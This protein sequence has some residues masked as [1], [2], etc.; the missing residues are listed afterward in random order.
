MKIAMP[1][2]SPAE[3]EPLLAAGADEIYFG[4]LPP[5]WVEQFGENTINR[6]TIGNLTTLDELRY[7]IG[8]AHMYG[9]QVS[10]TF[11]SQSYSDQ[12]LPDLLELARYFADWGG[13]SLIVSDIGFLVELANAKI[14]LRIHISSIA[15]C[16]NTQAAMF[17]KDLGATRVI[18]PRHTTL[19]EV[20]AIASG[21][22]MMEYEVFIQNDGCPFEEGLCQTIHLPS[23]LGGPIC[24]DNYQVNFKKADGESISEK[25][26]ALLNFNQSDYYKYLWFKFSCGFSTTKEGYPHGPCG[27]CAIPFF[28]DCGVTAIKI[29]GREFP[30]DRKLK[31][32]EMVRSVIKKMDAGLS[33]NEV[34]DFAQR[35]RGKQAYC[36]SGYMC[37]YPDVLEHL[38]NQ[39]VSV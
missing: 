14:G 15:T 33:E 1:I 7:V 34:A 3:A 2:A 24:M 31:S 11:N 19:A 29:A 6:R 9:K 35:I 4:M 36:K 27:L 22:P 20:K 32:L 39:T 38:G 23:N 17:Y 30:L 26:L 5:K 18:F 28:R 12:Q 21:P 16:R 10:L 37:Y 8:A 13:N 25:E